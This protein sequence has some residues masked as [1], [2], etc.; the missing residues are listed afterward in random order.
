MT[1]TDRRNTEEKTVLKLDK[2]GMFWNV[3]RVINSIF[4][5]QSLG[6]K[7]E[8]LWADSLYD[9]PGKGQPNTWLSYF[10][11]V[12]P[13]VEGSDGQ[14]TFDVFKLHKE[15]GFP[16]LT[17]DRYNFQ[18]KMFGM[19]LPHD[20]P[21]AARIIEN[22]IQL[23]PNIKSLIGSFQNDLFTGR[24]IGLHIRGRGRSLADG[25]GLMRYFLD[26]S[27]PIP[28]SA[29]FAA[30]DRA[31]LQFPQ[32]KIFACS[33]SNDV[34]ARCK[35][36][37]GDRVFSYN[38]TRSNF[39]EMHC[40]ASQSDTVKISPHKLGTDIL[41]EA[42]SLAICDFF[43]HGNSN[44]ANFVLCKSPN[45]PHDYVY[46]P[47]EAK[48]VEVEKQRITRGERSFNE[49]P[50]DWSRPK[51]GMIRFRTQSNRQKKVNTDNGPKTVW[52]R[53]KSMIFG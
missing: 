10:K 15:G 16:R 51:F 6:L 32:A 28:Y 19:K 29:Y 40:T 44:V 23:Q 36:K 22:N 1:N 43:V 5:A 24:V 50:A 38:A 21:A 14:S 9:E 8:V 3:N 52:K 18:G 17:G 27:E 45:L 11:P 2:D 20:R 53:L 13:E 42:Y 4:I 26:P 39:G 34:L 48:Y 31:L 12:F 47:V 7:F 46:Q 49:P 37:Y 41:I 30:V 25:T 33:D 35:Q